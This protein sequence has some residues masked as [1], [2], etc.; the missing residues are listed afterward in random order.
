MSCCG[1][2][3]H[4]SSAKGVDYLIAS[5]IKA[6]EQSKVPFVSLPVC[7]SFVHNGVP[8]TDEKETKQSLKEK[9]LLF[10]LQCVACSFPRPPDK[11]I[12]SLVL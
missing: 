8:I 3:I 6:K 12:T 7:I 5:T 9:F 4:T 2:L 11:F 10:F 1:F